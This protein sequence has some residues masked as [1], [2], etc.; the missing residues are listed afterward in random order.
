MYQTYAFNKRPNK[1]IKFTTLIL[2]CFFF[3]TNAQ[4][5][6]DELGVNAEEIS[7]P[8][9]SAHHIKEYNRLRDSHSKHFDAGGGSVAAYFSPIPIHFQVAGSWL[10][11]DNT[12]RPNNEAEYYYSHPAANIENNVKTLFPSNFLEDALINRYNG[13]LFFEKIESV[14]WADA[15]GN[16]LEHLSLNSNAITF[17]VKGNS[18]T[19]SGFHPNLELKYSLCNTGRKFNLYVT[20]SDFFNTMPVGAAKLAIR[21]RISS[22]S[23]FEVMRRGAYLALMSGGEELFGYMNPKMLDADEANEY[24]ERAAEMKHYTEQG[25]LVVLSAFDVTWMT[26]PERVYPLALDPIVNYFPTNTTFWSGY[27]TSSTSKN[28]GLLRITDGNT[29]SWAKYNTSGLPSN[30]T[31]VSAQY[32]GYHYT[33]SSNTS[34]KF[35]RLRQLTTDPVPAASATLWTESL[36]GT[37]VSAD[38]NWAFSSNYEWKNVMLNTAGVAAVQNSVGQGWYALGHQ[39][40][41]GG[42]SFAYH[43]G[44]DGLA[45]FVTY[46]RVDYTTGPAAPNV[47][48]SANPLCGVSSTTLIAQGGAGTIHWYTG[49]CGGSLIGTGDTLTVFPTQATTYYGRSFDNGQFSSLC[50]S[51]DITIGPNVNPPTGTGATVNCGA[52]INLS[53]TGSLMGYRWYADPLAQNLVDTGAAITVS[54]QFSTDTF[55]VAAVQSFGPPPAT[56][57]FTNANSTGRT[58]P[59]QSQVNSAYSGT[60]LAGQVTIT[61]NGIQNW[62]V[63]T[64]G[65]YTIEAWGAQGSNATASTGGLGAYMSGEFQLTQ[66]E[67]IRVLVGQNAPPNS[68]RINLS[69]AGGGGTFVTRS[70]HNNSGSILLVAGGGGG[71]GNER[72]STSNATTSN[73]GLAGSHGTGG[74]NGNGGTSGT[75]SAG[76]GAGFFTNGQGR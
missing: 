71:T 64:T 53:A 8:W 68:N 72:P 58:G 7:A 70:P 67:V 48:A 3:S 55:Y 12:I 26:S 32:F 30:A 17:D 59:T 31:I 44:H 75:S 2:L 29:A 63:P 34:T 57:T 33:G 43:Y 6:R 15:Q 5:L 25:E 10:D 28:T 38:F 41:S 21:E 27:Q 76:A 23:P 22:S 47:S 37:I 13:T 20:S 35:C 18:I 16:E 52:P 39:Y 24:N 45:G 14:Y 1:A 42:T 74:T 49:S 11:I 60:P 50:G 69:S 36:N 61:G 62:T 9:V 73:N 56:Y 19:Y 66:G 54:N 65:T 51:I 46:L 40:A 4:G